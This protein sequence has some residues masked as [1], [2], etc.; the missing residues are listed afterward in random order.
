MD[1][2]YQ[3]VPKPQAWKKPHCML[4]HLSEELA[5]KP[6]EARAEHE[7]LGTALRPAPAHGSW[8]GLQGRG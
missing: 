7:T 4:P 5:E 3:L 1:M 2:G 8:A 6:S